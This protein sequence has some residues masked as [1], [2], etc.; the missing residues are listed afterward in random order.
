MSTTRRNRIHGQFAWRLIEMLES[1]AYQVLSLA[2][3]RVLARIE[4]ELAHHGGNGN[5]QL[6]VTFN[7]FVHYGVRRHAI[8]PALRDLEALGFIEITERGRAGNAEFRQPHKFRL[9]YRHVARANPTDEWRRIKTPEQANALIGRSMAKQKSRAGFDTK[10]SVESV[11]TH[12]QFH[13]VE[14]VITAKVSKASLLSIS[15]VGGRAGQVAGSLPSMARASIPAPTPAS[16]G[17]APPGTVL[18]SAPSSAAPSAGVRLAGSG[19]A[20][21]HVHEGANRAAAASTASSRSNKLRRVR[22]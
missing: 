11:T 6:P 7:D 2:A 5:G 12:Q 8:A 9:T 13:S 20:T 14:S 16:P 22:L 3:H 17:T 1:P 10:A 21:V 4:I 19:R 18:A 15:R